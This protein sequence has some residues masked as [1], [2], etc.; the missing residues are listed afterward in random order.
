MNSE[1]YLSIFF[2]AFY[3]YYVLFLH[4]H[5]VLYQLLLFIHLFLQLSLFFIN[6]DYFDTCFSIFL[7][8]MHLIYI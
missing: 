1:F 5:Y 7:I 4:V 6:K 2:S 8:S 3:E